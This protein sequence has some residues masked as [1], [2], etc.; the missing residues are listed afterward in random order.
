MTV[1]DIGANIGFYTILLSK[2][3]GHSGLVIAYEPEMQ[4]FYNLKNIC[5]N[6]KNINLRPVACS[7]KSGSLSLYFSEHM[8]IDHQT[9]DSGEGRFF[10]DIPCIAIDDDLDESQNIGFIKID[11]Q[12]YD[13]HAL[14]G[15]KRTFQRSN[16]L[17]LLGEFWPYALKKA[18][19]EPGDYI[20]FL[21]ELGFKLC[22]FHGET[23]P[24]NPDKL[25]DKYYYTDFYASKG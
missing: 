8:N 20:H 4:N 5:R 14:L 3:V 2:L 18:G 22:F 15:M 17:T 12:G 21:E 19:V 10:Q 11:I 16:E 13:Y 9:F 24:L 6:R 1:L 7:N 25:M 23:D